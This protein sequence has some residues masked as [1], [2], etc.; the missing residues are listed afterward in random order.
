MV[1][2]TT[3]QPPHASPSAPPWIFM[4]L[5]VPF[6]LVGGFLGVALA[7]E[8]KQAGISAAAIAG[9]IALSYVP[10][11]WKFLWAPLVD[12]SW[13]RRH[14][15][16]AST[17]VTGLGMVAMAWF[18][19]DALHW[20]ALTV[21]M[22]ITNITSTV[23][24]MSVDSLMA[25][26]TADEEKGRAAGWFQ[27]GNLGGGAL[28]GGLALWLVQD[29]QVSVLASGWVMAALCVLSCVPLLILPEPAKTPH[30]S[31]A[32]HASVLA[33]F[34][35]VLWGLWGD[36]WSVLSSRAGLLAL[37]VCFLPIGSGA[38]SGLWSVMADDWHASANTVALVNGGLGGLASAA[39][40]LL[41]GW[42][43]DRLERKTAY[44]LFGLLQVVLAVVM[45]LA[46]KSELSFIVLASAYNVAVGMAYAGFSALVL[47][48]I[49]RG[50][51]A[52]KYN[53]MASLSNVPI[54]YMTWV[55]GQAY[56]RWGMSAMLNVEAGIGVLGLLVFGA[57][58]LVVR[59][60]SQTKALGAP[61]A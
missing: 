48:V 21:V 1:P 26:S 24:G 43:C 47:E 42:V 17:L 46:P 59:S 12:L 52:T 25:H 49:G 2:D 51:A 15:Y 19:R 37:I 16:L 34:K 20:G 11:T 22:L 45:A 55:D 10:N 4:V 54:G 5:I 30:E 44:C 14:W 61:A 8:L 39:G 35:G 29:W 41:G 60:R 23:S 40:C 7:Y 50:A 27:A 28:G 18:S 58:L 31:R 9:L 38:V 6:G 33:R 3:A 56:E 57:A 36:L 32:A 53:I 13:T